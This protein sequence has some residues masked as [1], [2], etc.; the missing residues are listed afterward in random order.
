M[1]RGTTAHFKF[2]LPYDCSDLL[3]VKITFWQPDND[4]PAS[5]RPLPIVKVLSQCS[6]TNEPDELTVSLTQEETL[7]FS[8]D[9]RA[10]VQLKGSSVDGNVFAS[11]KTQLIVYPVCD[12]EVLDGSPTPTPVPGDVP[13]I[14]DGGT[15]A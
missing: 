8:D 12:D 2:R 7:R 3:A 4:G 1:I 5:D 14:L 6:T 15:I 9:R 10:Y 11:K 13:I